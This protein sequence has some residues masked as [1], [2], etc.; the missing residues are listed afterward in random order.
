MGSDRIDGLTL[1]LLTL[2][3]VAFTY[4]GDEIEME[5]YRDISWEDTTDP[6]ACNSNPIDYK[7]LSRDPNRTPLVIFVV[8]GASFLTLLE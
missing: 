3:G 7:D 6:W 4:S 1:L 2:P 8:I 5:D